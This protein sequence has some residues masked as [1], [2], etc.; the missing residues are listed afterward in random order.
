MTARERRIVRLKK[1]IADINNDLD[2][3]GKISGKIAVLDEEINRKSGPVD[4]RD[5]MSMAAYLHH[6]YTGLEAVFERISVDFDGGISNRG[7]YHRE[8]LRSMTL[9]IDGVRPK[10]ISPEL[11]EELDD[12]RKF[13]H[14]FRHAYAGELGWKK[15]SHLSENAAE[16]FNI[17]EVNVK[18][19]ISYIMVLVLRL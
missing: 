16:I 13:R 11:V 7:D 14:M 8:L 4:D 12:Y 1:L 5:I 3:V 9:E 15:M 2:A 18:V 6:Y 10:V 19:F 17:V